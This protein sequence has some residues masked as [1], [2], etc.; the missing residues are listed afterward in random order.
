MAPPNMA[1]SSI[2]RLLN[3]SARCPQMGAK[4]AREIAA[5]DWTA[6]THIFS[7]RGSVIPISSERNRGMTGIDRA[8]PA[9]ARVSAIKIAM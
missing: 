9:I 4:I 1:R 3:T 8:K 2:I 7:F 6:P 5:E